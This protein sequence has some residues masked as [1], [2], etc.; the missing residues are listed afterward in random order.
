MVA[1]CQLVWGDADPY[2][3]W[4][5]AGQRLHDLLPR[6][7][8]TRIATCGHFTPLECPDALLGAML[9]WRHQAAP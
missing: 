6:T 4:A 5:T 8:V 7:A 9:G 1:P 3:P 2:Q